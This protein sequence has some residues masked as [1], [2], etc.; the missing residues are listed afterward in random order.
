M[1]QEAA[2]QLIAERTAVIEPGQSVVS[3]GDGAESAKCKVDHSPG[4]PQEADIGSHRF[5]RLPKRTQSAGKKL[6]KPLRIQELPVML[7]PK[8]DVVATVASEQHS[9]AISDCLTDAQHAER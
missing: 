7:V 1:R 9:H 4:P 6:A 2:L 5:Q 8:E 3:V